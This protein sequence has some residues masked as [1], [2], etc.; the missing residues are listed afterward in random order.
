MVLFEAAARG[1][2]FCGGDCE[3][4]D[5][6]DESDPKRCGEGD[7]A[8]G[9]RATGPRRAGRWVPNFDGGADESLSHFEDVAAV[10]L[11]KAQGRAIEKWE[12]HGGFNE[13]ARLLFLEKRGQRSN[14]GGCFAPH[15]TAPVRWGTY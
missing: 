9:P 3:G 6:D 10:A 11:R 14:H 15:V 2:Q 13:S 5:D 12:E 1:G 7:E 8:T 4:G